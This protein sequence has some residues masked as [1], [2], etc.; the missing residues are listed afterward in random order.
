[1]N[2]YCSLA[3]A[4]T[5]TLSRIFRRQESAQALYGPAFGRQGL[6]L[7]QVHEGVNLGRADD[8]ELPF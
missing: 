4:F 6:C 5:M 3:T 8:R 7:V 1:M 2:R